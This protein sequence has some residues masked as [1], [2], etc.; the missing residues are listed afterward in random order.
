M[1]QVCVVSAH[2]KQD[3]RLTGGDVFR[4][5][6]ESFLQDYTFGIPDPVMSIV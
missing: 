3:R 5:S 4:V 6:P 2:I 1:E